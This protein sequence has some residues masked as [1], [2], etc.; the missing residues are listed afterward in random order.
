MSIEARFITDQQDIAARVGVS[1][2][3]LAAWST[4]TDD[5]LPPDVPIGPPSVRTKAWVDDYL[6][7]A[8]AVLSE[9]QASRLVHA[10]EAATTA[11]IFQ[12]AKVTCF[13]GQLVSMTER[14]RRPFVVGVDEESAGT[15]RP[16]VEVIDEGMKLTLRPVQSAGANAVELAGRLELSQIGAVG[17]ASAVLRGKAATIQVPRV[18]RRRI[19]LSSAIPDRQ[20]LLLG[21]IATREEKKFFYLMV[22]VRRV[23]EGWN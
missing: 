15:R 20:S 7:V 13:N 1:W 17:T 12:T 8:V 23:V 4:G 14:T 10:A 18:T 9:Q 6:P 11:N 16:R 2:E 19:D 22:T 3:S 5:G 21:F